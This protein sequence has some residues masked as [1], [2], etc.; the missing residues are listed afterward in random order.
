MSACIFYILDGEYGGIRTHGKLEGDGF[1]RG[2]CASS[3]FGGMYM[4]PGYWVPDW[5]VRW[6]WNLSIHKISFESVNPIQ[7]CH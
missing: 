2:A 6:N 5:A 7:S 3:R 4:C 1:V